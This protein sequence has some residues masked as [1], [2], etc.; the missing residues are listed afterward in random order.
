MAAMTKLDQIRDEWDRLASAR[1]KM[2][3]MKQD[4][5]T[6]KRLKV[7]CENAVGKLLETRAIEFSTRVQ[8]YL[9][10]DWTFNIQLM[11]GNKEVFRMGIMRNGRLHSALSGAEWTSVVT[12]IAM[13]VAEGLDDSLP[14]VLIPDDRAWDGKTLSSVMRGFSQFDGQVI[15][16]STIRPT[17]RPPKGWTIIDMDEM[18]ASWDSVDTVEEAP[19][20]TPKV[21]KTS[22]NHASGGFRVTTRSALILEEAGFESS[23]IESMSRETVASIIKDGLAPENISVNQDGS[24]QIIR[25]AKVLP[26]PPAPKV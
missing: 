4:V 10:N 2:M 25:S 26:M 17:G 19:V 20:E 8:K 14:A 13:S 15:M 12:A 23:V 6:Y 24:Y 16:A 1:D 9:P 5:E 11:D 18:S 21:K 22:I 3:S 7:S